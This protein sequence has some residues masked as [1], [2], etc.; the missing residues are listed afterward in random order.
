MLSRIE[1]IKETTATH[2]SYTYLGAGAAVRI[3]YS[4]PQVRLDLWGG[5]SGTYSSG[6]DRFGRIAARL[7]AGGFQPAAHR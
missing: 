6:L 4:Q 2:A 1:A 3:D 7:R 5:S